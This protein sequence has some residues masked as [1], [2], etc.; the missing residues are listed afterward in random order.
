MKDRLF[1][2][3]HVVNAM[4]DVADLDD[5]LDGGFSSDVV[6]LS[7]YDRAT[8]IFQKGAGLTGTAKIQIC[9]CDD[10]T[11]S[12]TTAIAFDSWTCTTGDTWGDKVT[13]VAAGFTTTAGANQIYAFEVNAAELSS[14]DQYLQF[15]GVPVTDDPVSASLTCILS[16]ARYMHE[17]KQTAIT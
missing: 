17:V 16:N 11:P 7:N 2:N 9:S 3:I 13:I 1:Q 15:V 5:I 10:V 12:T 14:T 6:N 8:F 4:P